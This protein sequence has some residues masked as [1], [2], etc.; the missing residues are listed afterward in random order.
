M[1]P[2]DPLQVMRAFLSGPAS[3]GPHLACVAGVSFLCAVVARR[4]SGGWPAPGPQPKR[5]PTTTDAQTGSVP[6]VAPAARPRPAAKPRPRP[7][8]RPRAQGGFEGGDGQRAG[9]AAGLPASGWRRSR[10]RT[11]DAAPGQTRPEQ[12]T[13]LEPSLESGRAHVQVGPPRPDSS[14]RQQ[15]TSGRASARATVG[16]PRQARLAP[17]PGQLRHG[18]GRTPAAGRSVPLPGGACRRFRATRTATRAASDPHVAFP[19]RRRPAGAPEG[20]LAGVPASC[21]PGGAAANGQDHRP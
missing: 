4:A 9:T 6:R 14:S 21:C 5:P 18:I 8:H 2:G 10:R 12:R 17:P 1:A 11:G 15:S 20:G 7:N 19:N 13:R 3:A 16:V